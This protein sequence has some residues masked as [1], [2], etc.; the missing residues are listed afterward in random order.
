MELSQE[1]FQEILSK[2]PEGTDPNAVL[3]ALAKKGHSVKKPPSLGRQIVEGVISPFARTATTLINPI[4]A[5]GKIISGAL[6]KEGLTQEELQS[7]NKALG[8]R[9]DFGVLATPVA[10][11]GIDEEGNVDTGK[12]IREMFGV[13][14]ELGSSVAGT[15]K[16]I[17]RLLGLKNIAKPL[18]QAPKFAKTLGESTAVGTIGGLGVGLQ[19]DEV[20]PQSVATATSI[21]TGLGIAAPLAGRAIGKAVSPLIERIRSKISAPELKVGQDIVQEGIEGAKTKAQATINDLQQRV[22][23]LPQ[24]TSVKTKEFGN[25]EGYATLNSL[26]NTLAQKRIELQDL[27][28]TL[29]ETSLPLEKIQQARLQKNAEIMSYRQEQK[30]LQE[31]LNAIKQESQRTLQEARRINNDL[32]ASTKKEADESIRQQSIKIKNEIKDIKTRIKELTQ[33][34][35]DRLTREIAS[36]VEKELKK[37]KTVEQALIEPSTSTATLVESWAKKNDLGVRASVNRLAKIVKEGLERQKQVG[38]LENQLKNLIKAKINPE[39][40]IVEKLEYHKELARRIPRYK[41]E[42][43]KTIQTSKVKKDL[44]ANIETLSLI[45]QKNP[46]EVIKDIP[47]RSDQKLRLDELLLQRPDL[48]EEQA[49]LVILRKDYSSTLKAIQKTKRDIEKINELKEVLQNEIE[50]NR[51][52]LLEEI[53]KQEEVLNKGFILNEET[54]RSEFVQKN[55]T[56]LENL[57]VNQNINLGKITKAFTSFT[58]FLKKL[59]PAGRFVSDRITEMNSWI[60][61]YNQRF[62]KLLYEGGVF[63]LTPE[64][65]VRV[66]QALDKNTIEILEPKLQKSALAIRA[67]FAEYAKEAY[68]LKVK[69]W[70]RDTGKARLFN[71]SDIQRALNGEY[72]PLM[73]KKEI[74]ERLQ[75]NDPEVVA[76]IAEYIAQQ[77]NIPIQEATELAQKYGKSISGQFEVRIG[78]DTQGFDVTRGG[79]ME[80]ARS[81]T[82]IPPEYLVD[83]AVE[84]AINYSTRGNHT[85]AQF[86]TLGSYGDNLL[87]DLHDRI[88]NER[89][90]S[91]YRDYV[92][93]SFGYTP[94]ITSDMVK[95]FQKASATLQLGLSFITNLGGVA[96]TAGLNNNIV[97]AFGDLITTFSKAIVNKD[98]RRE[99]LATY[100]PQQI[101]AD[102]QSAGS[103]WVDKVQDVLMSP[104]AIFDTI[105]RG[106]SYKTTQAELIRISEKLSKGTLSLPEQRYL[107]T[108]L[109]KASLSLDDL[110]KQGG[111]F[112]SEQLALLG[113]IG[114]NLTQFSY[115]KSE[116]PIFLNSTAGKVFLPYTRYTAQYFQFWKYMQD[117]LLSG[118]P[119]PMIKLIASG[120]V[121]YSGTQLLRNMISANTDREFVQNMYLVGNNVFGSANLPV[122]VVSQ[123]FYLDKNGNIKVNEFGGAAQ[124]LASAKVFEDLLLSDKSLNDKLYR[125]LSRYPLT[126]PL[127]ILLEK[128]E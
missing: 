4:E 25:D 21:G 1:K 108:M 84:M 98:Y 101:S 112:T 6:D 94:E 92:R 41:Q 80:T 16:I 105:V 53:N 62:Y 38:V 2:L 24:N 30:T 114:Q 100:T 122:F 51:L 29:Q 127:R 17:P 119:L 66:K 86:R 81:D 118:N 31:T 55:A 67:M 96:N 46:L 26:D 88:N 11:I 56:I 117:E 120:I 125:A 13:G 59:G 58:E 126:Q 115:H 28:K 36:K 40:S 104:T 68:K 64:E 93:D 48:T 18:T 73:M 14:A 39:P 5:T 123:M 107:T 110:V 63:E 121:A 87:K 113:N 3:V 65:G 45:R 72:V 71:S 124:V 52:F 128:P 47:L 85:L 76:R 77:K 7:A 8:K 54:Q 44:D 19:G 89:V 103:S 69:I 37:G 74:V 70:D 91:L 95:G 109:N 102:F 34:K 99:L 116:L 61:T 22:Q 35:N 20:T 78:K 42:I 75:E 32:I 27:E 79:F 12:Q 49:K 90:K 82:P 9:R 23:K 50:K 111:K 83:N 33:N 106:A 57:P 15:T 10:P 97:R 60:N 43:E